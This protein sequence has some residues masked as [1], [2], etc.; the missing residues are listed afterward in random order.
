MNMYPC[1]LT[2]IQIYSMWL[3]ASIDGDNNLATKVFEVDV[4]SNGNAGGGLRLS[5]T[6]TV[7]WPYLAALTTCWLSALP[8]CTFGLNPS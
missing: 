6:Y 3:C 4:G 2:Y 8:L 1:I 5:Q 7:L